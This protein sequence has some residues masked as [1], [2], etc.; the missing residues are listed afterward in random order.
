MIKKYTMW[1]IYAGVVGLL[2]FGAVIRT[3]AKTGDNS[4]PESRSERQEIELPDQSS[5]GYGS[6]GEASERKFVDTI[7]GD[8]VHL[9]EDHNNE[10]S[11]QAGFVKDL[12]SKSLWIETEG[13]E[14]LEITRRPWRFILESGL[15]LSVGD[16]VELE[17]FLENDEFEISYLANLTSGESLQIRDD[18]GRPLWSG[19]I[20]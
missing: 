7:T 4:Q 15:V 14:N 3:R 6:F 19:G 5:E 20:D 9:A 16:A 11:S 13:G 18:S 17:G 8:E 10:W 2:I 1:S 12:N